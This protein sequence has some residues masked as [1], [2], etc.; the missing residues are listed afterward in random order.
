MTTNGIVPDWQRLGR[1]HIWLPYTQMKNAPEPLAVVGA[2]GSRLRL[3]DGRELVD[4][5]ASWW[6]VAHGYDHPHI[7]EAIR[8]QAN[9][10]QHV[11]LGG[12]AHEQAYRLAARLAAL[13]PGTLNHAFF[14]ESGSISVEVAMKM[15]VQFWL[16]Q[17]VRR[18]RFVSFRA[19][20]HGDSFAT[21][22]VCD[23]EEGMHALFAGV[24]P[25]QFVVDLPVDEPRTAA[26]EDLLA[27]QGHQVAA[28]L[29]EPLVQGA[30]GMRMHDAAT[31]KRIREACDRHG[32]L[33]IFDEIFVGFGRIG[34]ALFA[35]E[36]A[37]VIP[38]IITLSKALT[39]G[40]LP[41]AATVASD[42]V[43]EA[44]LA[45]EPG[46]AL[47]HGPTYMGNALACAAA[48]ASLDLF[49]SEPRLEQAQAI[50]R[51]LEAALAPLADVPGVRDVRVQGAIG[52]VQIDQLGNAA[53]LGEAFVEQG[54]WL[55]PFGD[56]IYT[57]PP[58]V[59]DEEEVAR[60]A[61]A[62][63]KVVHA[64]SGRRGQ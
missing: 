15:A 10:L 55:R 61:G 18:T 12:L 53:G 5:I 34:E 9:R 50:E 45:D 36:A 30:G 59:A 48:N 63:V 41:L 27:R 43:F 20:Y 1:R 37:G 25:E 35:C 32:L 6:T 22:S 2:R 40:T 58:L 4:G 64:W 19:G 33:L 51:Q 7:R 31:L 47:M 21:M 23:P 11:M 38:D 16:N 28:V 54:V 52:V 57:T 24:V 42:A 14:S 39:G 26:F 46:R 49:A 60:I 29:V 56:I 3:A 13:L 44:F 8:D 17:G 62:I